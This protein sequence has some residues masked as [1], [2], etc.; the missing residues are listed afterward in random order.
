MDG[1]HW[2]PL[3]RELRVLVSAAHR[4]STDSLLLADFS[5]PKPRTHCADLGSGC[6]VI[7]LLWAY[8]AAPASVLA[9]ELQPDA[10]RL[11][12][13]SAGANGLSVRV[14][15]GDLRDY[16]VHLPHQGLDLI[17]C[18]P[19]YF[20]PGRGQPPGSE[21]RSLARHGQALPLALL[22]EAARFALKTG[23]RLCFCLPARRLT[24]AM[25]TMRGWQLEPKRLRLVQA[26]PEKEPYLLLMECRRGGRP[27][28][29]VGLPL[30]IQRED[31][32]P[33][34]EMVRIYGDYLEGGGPAEKGGL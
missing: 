27:G 4:F 14:V 5:L 1:A 20:S 29:E 21:S 17:A 2:E 16:R 12:A 31:G 32:G 33:S 10:A 18:N 15:C 28:V 19:P 11:A 9:L 13:A 26:R 6:G 8:R 34:E 24:E 25:V 23:G 30:V 22:A 7:P 3:G